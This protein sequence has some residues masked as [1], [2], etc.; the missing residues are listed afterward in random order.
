MNYLVAKTDKQLE[1]C[2]RVLYPIQ[3]VSKVDIQKTEKKQDGVS[4]FC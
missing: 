4:C 3:R 1:I 2:L